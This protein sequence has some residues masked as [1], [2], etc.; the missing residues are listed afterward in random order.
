MSATT[1]PSVVHADSQGRIVLQ[2]AMY[3]CYI[4]KVQKDGTISLTP[5]VNAKS[6]R[7]SKKA[8][9]MIESSMT[10]LKKGL[11]SEPITVP[12]I[13]DDDEDLRD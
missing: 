10:N 7:I 5:N 12:H 8:Y 4:V 3:D 1:N 11:V 13:E 9:D 6:F 2:N